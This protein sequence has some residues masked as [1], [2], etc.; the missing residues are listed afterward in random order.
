[1]AEAL[2]RLAL[3]SR[4]FRRVASNYATGIAIVTTLHDGAHHAM[5]ANSFTTVSLDPL[6]V[7][8][9]VQQGTRFHDAVTSCGCWAASFLSS[10]QAQLARWFA[11]A[12]RPLADQFSGI[13]TL[14][15]SNGSLVLSGSLGAIAASTVTTVAAG[16]HD[17]LIGVATE[18]LGRPGEP[19]PDALP[20]VYF[21]SAYGSWLR[22][23]P[24]QPNI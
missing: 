19:A 5:T 9:C 12:G 11:T 2:T 8:V 15:S 22:G 3:T 20:T 24:D 17:I 10:E 21:Q 23:N 14:S 1:M 7:S 13:P 4:D 18:L 6:M 16:D